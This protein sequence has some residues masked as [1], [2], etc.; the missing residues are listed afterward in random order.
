M[1]QIQMDTTLHN[2][3]IDKLIGQWNVINYGLFVTADS[4]LPDSK[5]IYRTQTILNEQNKDNGKWTF[6]DKC[7]KSELKNIKDIPNKTKKYKIINGKYLAMKYLN[8]YCGATVIGLTKDGYLIIDDHTYRTLAKKGKYLV[9]RTSI[10][11]L[12]LKKSAT[13]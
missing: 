9:I 13:A 2:F 8:G 3:P 12:I 11:R 7:S 6:T 1:G 4:I 5:I 10:R